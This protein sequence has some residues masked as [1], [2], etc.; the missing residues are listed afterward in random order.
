MAVQ[1]DLG[2][3]NGVGMARGGQRGEGVTTDSWYL[4]DGNFFIRGIQVIRDDLSNQTAAPPPEPT[5][6]TNALRTAVNTRVSDTGLP[7]IGRRTPFI[8]TMNCRQGKGGRTNRILRFLF[9]R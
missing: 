5:P 4:T 8:Q 7:L 6:F 3:G 1:A 2:D 9:L